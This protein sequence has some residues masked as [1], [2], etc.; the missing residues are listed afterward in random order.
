MTNFVNLTPHPVNLLL[1]DR[2][3]VIPAS[4]TLARQ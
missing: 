4:G 3:I 2:E 1:G